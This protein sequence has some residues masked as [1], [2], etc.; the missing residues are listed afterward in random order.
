VHDYK[1]KE[2]YPVACYVHPY[3]KNAIG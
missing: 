3:D 2:N 1:H